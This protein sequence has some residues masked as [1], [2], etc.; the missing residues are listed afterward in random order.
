MADDFW[1]AH[2]KS[3]PFNSE[4]KLALKLVNTLSWTRL[5]S[6]ALW[7]LR[8]KDIGVLFYIISVQTPPSVKKMSI[9]LKQREKNCSDSPKK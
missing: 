6:W 2:N 1:K 3:R 8:F 7:K 4:M 5:N 9:C